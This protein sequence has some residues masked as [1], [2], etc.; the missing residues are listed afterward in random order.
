[1]KRGIGG[2]D[3]QAAGRPGLAVIDQDLA[4]LVPGVDTAQGLGMAVKV[5]H[6]IFA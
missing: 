3:R 4:G 5:K 1:M 2:G 6:G